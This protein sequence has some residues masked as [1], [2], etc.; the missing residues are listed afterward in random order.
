VFGPKGSLFIGNDGGV[1]ALTSDGKLTN[2]NAGLRITQFTRGGSVL[3]RRGRVV[4]GTQDNGT[5][6]VSRLRSKPPRAD[7]DAQWI[8]D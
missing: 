8:C 1:S 5:I 6:D 7:S 4:A 3:R 2:R